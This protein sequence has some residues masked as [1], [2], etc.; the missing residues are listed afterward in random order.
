M[1]TKIEKIIV[2][3]PITKTFTNGNSIIFGN[4]IS[5]DNQKISYEFQKG[6]LYNILGRNGE[7]KTT[8]L[9]IISL[10][11]G[12]DG[13]ISIENEN[14][15]IS[16]VNIEKT[17]LDEMRRSN[18]SFIFQDPHLINVFSIEENLKIINNNLN[19]NEDFYLLIER[20]SKLMN[21]DSSS[22]IVEKMK[23]LIEEK[24]NSPYFLSGGE[25]QLLS[26]IRSMIKP[27][28]I[29]FADEP[30]A[31][32]DTKLKEFV[33]FQLSEYIKDQDMFKDIR[34]R[35][36]ESRNT[37]NMVIMITHSHNNTQD[38]KGVLDKNWT[39][40]IVVSKK[41]DIKNESLCQ[42]AEL[43]LERYGF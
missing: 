13:G 43:I 37:I 14:L 34:N 29:I 23:Y 25:K 2:N 9:N 33:E 20:I 16:S 11:T 17:N 5:T 3:L 19:Y 40:K 6:Y 8:F 30:W 28:G 42:R 38:F 4:S 22:Y 27:S 10:L 39:K 18:F 24:N 7:G 12:F 35:N 1:K 21:V 36:K 31:N 26:F 15:I 41:R 32:M